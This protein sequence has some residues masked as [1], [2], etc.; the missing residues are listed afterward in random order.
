MKYSETT[1][2]LFK[3]LGIASIAVVLYGCGSGS[4]ATVQ[5]NPVTQVD[6]VENYNGPPP[7]S[8]DVQ[9]FKLNVWDNLVPNNRCG[10]CH[11]DSQS[12]RFVRADDI[13]LAYNE[14]N[15]LVDLTDPGNSRLVTKVRGGHNCWLTSND[16]CGDIMT[17]YIQA[18]AGDTVGSEGKQIQLVAPTLRDPGESKNWPETA[19]ETQFATTVHPLLT[20]YCASCHTDAA[21]VPQSPY[22]AS[23]D[24]DVAYDQSKSKIDLDTPA[25]SRF[26]VRLGD[27]FHNCW[28]DC[29]SDA[30][31]MLAAIA[32]LTGDIQPTEVDAALVTSKAMNIAQDGIVASSGGRHESNVIALYEFKTGSGS[33]A[34]DTSGVEPSLNL[35]LSGDAQWVGGCGVQVGANGKAQGS[36]S[37]SRK[38]F[39]LITA[40]NEYSIEAWVAPGNVVQDGPARIVSYSGGSMTR[41][42]MLGQTL[43]NYDFLNRQANSDQ[44]GDP[45]LSTADADEDLQ[46]TL[47]HVV[48]TYDPIEGRKIYVNGQFTDDVDPTPPGLLAD[49]DDTFALVVGAE[50][51]NDN[52]WAGVVRLLAIHNRALTG[53]QVVQNYDVG[54]G[55]KYFLLFNVSDHVG[56]DDAYVVFETG[57][58]DSYSYLFNAPFFIA[59]GADSIPADIQMMG[60]RIGVNGR[61]AAVSQSYANLDV[62]VTD[63]VYAVEGLQRLSSLGTVMPLEKGPADDEFFL[64]F[65]RLGDSENVVVEADPP[66]PTPPVAVPRGDTLGLRDFA[67]INATMSKLTTVPTTRVADT[68]ATVRQALPVQTGIAGFLPS[69][70]T[71]VIQLALGYCNT[72]VRDT[73]L[74]AAYFPNMN[75]GASHTTAFNDRSA[76]LDPLVTRMIG[77]NLSSQPD[78]TAEV[79]ALIDDMV[80]CGGSCEPDRTERIA[81]G[82]CTS[83]LASGAM[84]VQ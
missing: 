57:Q 30:N 54:V 51:D 79:N 69:Q 64:T 18:W 5:E 13:N 49:W 32:T 9:S 63:A 75:F 67:E 53:E 16:A 3:A 37:A 76:I 83:V 60:L 15:A 44:N 2:S 68:Y 14:T 56:I 7:A 80:N 11:N 20:Q 40:T 36:T 22:F 48:V 73:T 12:P 4:G 74:R 43:Y 47:Q 50:V 66:A 35:N 71:G 41:N 61:E 38:L 55:E 21:A 70:Q 72:L 33:T 39:D 25:N 77:S 34:F 46:A 27:E 78:I 10:S 23:S 59:L 31:D 42:F 81:V 19:A 6:E 62:T 45:Q 26:V 65:E 29:Q 52:Q 82:A 8:P 28:S 58:Y 84:M 24:V 1:S 17:S